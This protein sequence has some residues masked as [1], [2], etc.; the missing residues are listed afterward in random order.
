MIKAVLFDLDNTL[1]NFIRFKKIC[2]EA[3]IDS[4]IKSGLGI[5]KSRARKIFNELFKEINLDDRKIFQ[6]FLRKAIGKVDMK[7]LSSGIVAYRKA[8]INAYYTYPNVKFVL[9]SLRKKDIKT[10]IVSDAPRLKAWI[11]LTEIGLQNMFDVV[12]TFDDTKEI[13]PSPKPF[14][15]AL[16]KLRVKPEESIFIGDNIERDI[17]GAN[18]LGII[19][20]FAKYGKAKEIPR[21][22]NPKSKNKIEK[23]P[24]YVV[25]N[26]IEI[27]KILK[28][29][30][31]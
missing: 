23:T 31:S 11:R 5:S 21:K 1:V 20:V 3:A 9:S 18:R 24:D 14:L 19:S 7:I 16:K 28:E 10:A 12:V 17:V 22:L 27:L 4:M 2:I 30:N 25:K 13:K 26:P 8:R 6:K 29:L 15:K